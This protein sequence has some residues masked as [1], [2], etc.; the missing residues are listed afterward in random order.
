[1]STLSAPPER[2]P[3]TDGAYSLRAVKWTALAMAVFTFLLMVAGATV[4]TMDA[5]LSCPDWPLCHGQAFP[6]YDI[7]LPTDRDYTQIEM[8]AEMGHRAMAAGVSFAMLGLAGLALM[9]RRRKIIIQTVVAGLLLAT[10]IFLGAVTIWLAN[11]HLSVAAHLGGATAFLIALLVIYREAAGLTKP[12]TAPRWLKPWNV[13]GLI[14]LGTQI[15]LGAVI[16]KVP[17]ADL[18][19]PSFPHCGRED[20]TGVGDLVF[21]QML[22]RSLAFL[23]TGCIA[24]TIWRLRSERSMLVPAAVLGGIVLLQVFIGIANVFMLVPPV[25]SVS[26]MAVAVIL[27]VFLFFWTLSLRGARQ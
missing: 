1:M 6:P 14:V 17:G 10:Q 2:N 16:A 7:V 18:V 22:H 13:A 20:Y 11:V 8:I 24:L 4:R 23:I 12:I 9:T 27:F 25:L 21:L 19:C 26:H 5:G 3:Q 15:L